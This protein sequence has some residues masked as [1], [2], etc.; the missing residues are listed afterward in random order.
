VTGRDASPARAARGPVLAG[1]A[2][3]LIAVGGFGG[4][5][6][7]APL[8]SAVVAPAEVV[9]SAHRKTVQHLEG[10]IVA[11][12]PV[13]DGDVVAAGDVLLRLDDTRA[14]AEAARLAGARIEALARR[15]R[16]EADRDGADRVAFP[17]ELLGRAAGP[18]GRAAMD[19][20]SDLFRARRALLAEEA[21]ILRRRI[22]RSREE[23]AALE[24]RERAELRR[25]ELVGEEIEG[26]RRLVERGLE[27]RP[28]LLGLQRTAAG[29]G[30]ERAGMLGRI[31]EV[32]QSIAGT[33]LEIARLAAARAEQAA[34]GL[35]ETGAELRDL[36]E[37]LVA[38]RERLERTV[39]RAPQDGVVVGLRVH[40]VGG[41]VAPGEPIL[42]LSPR[43][44]G[45]VVDARVRP[46]D[47]DAVAPGMPARV[48]VTAYSQRTAPALEGRVAV[49]SADR[50]ADEATGAPYYRARIEL[51]PASLGAAPEVGLLPGM[52]AE[53]V[54]VSGGRTL[55]DYLVAPIAEAVGRGMLER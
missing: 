36:E 51:D 31:A 28:R 54:V 15:A 23:I 47:V 42:D 45:L 17:P 9:S 2:T 5:A 10:G 34:A 49:V 26:V 48:R 1:A 40:T 8:A 25:L 50:L 29:I 12:I 41:V 27:R 11:A 13:A 37:R 16:L 4:W 35:E 24:E 14:R 32:R 43:R 53:A 22:A 55:L 20:Q 38:A 33:E 39:V 7:T 52:P 19:G 46:E 18:G 3:V 6:A 44:G 30:S 21:A